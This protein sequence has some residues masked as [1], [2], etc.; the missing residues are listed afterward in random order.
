MAFFA[1]SAVIP[2]TSTDASLYFSGNVLY[3]FFPQPAIP[4]AISTQAKTTRS[5]I[6]FFFIFVL[7]ILI[8]YYSHS[9]IFYHFLIYASSEIYH[10]FSDYLDTLFI[11][12]ITK[13]LPN[14]A[15]Y[16][17]SV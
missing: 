1:S 14:D 16:V 2:P 4:N 11:I 17:T 9:T 12:M 13:K 6:L 7:F 8:L 3:A 5:F 15:Q 10:I